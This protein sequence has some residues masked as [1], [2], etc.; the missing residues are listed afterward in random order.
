MMDFIRCNFYKRTYNQNFY[1]KTQ[2]LNKTLFFVENMRIENYIGQNDWKAMSKKI[3]VIDKKI[4]FLLCKNS[5]LSNTAIA[6]ALRLK[7]EVVSYRIKK[8]F[9]QGFVKGFVTR[10]NPRK[11]GLLTHF[12]Y[13]KLKTPMQEKE[14]I[15]ELVKCPEVTNLKN[16]GGRFDIFMEV[17]AKDVHEFNGFIKRM[18][19]KYGPTVQE[20]V[21]LNNIA[22][23]PMDVDLIIEGD[24]KELGR[25]KALRETKGSSFHKELSQPRQMHSLAELDAADKSI[26]HKIKMDAR[27]N[28][29]DLAKELKSNA[30]AITRRIQRLVKEGVI[31]NFTS[32]PTIAMMGYQ[33]YQVLFNFRNLDESRFI[34]FLNLH[35]NIL[36]CHQL[37][38]NW[39]Y[40][41]N[42]FAKSNA[43]FHDIINDLRQEFPEN[44]VS[45][46]TV[47]VFNAFKSEQRI[48]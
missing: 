43:Q 29:K 31:I 33:M 25:L 20:Y 6:K 39:N 44:I 4:A 12:V 22:E 11:L 18:L 5:R 46:D 16:V 1:E 14:M 35:P 26:L 40:Q 38:G 15:D 37:V 24:K 2:Y 28:I 8:M 41:V 23:Y 47:M 21:F 10:I 17:T 32:Y 19:D 42:I 45:F 36:W 3:D 9:E 27:A 7:R 34:T 30:P 48:V 13:F